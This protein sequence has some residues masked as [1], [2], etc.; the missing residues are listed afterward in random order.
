[1]SEVAFSNSLAGSQWNRD[2]VVAR[3]RFSPG[4]GFENFLEKSEIDSAPTSVD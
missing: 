4:V 1:M 2:F 3:T